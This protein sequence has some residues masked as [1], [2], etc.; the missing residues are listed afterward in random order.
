MFN[1]GNT[2]FK[3]FFLVC[4]VPSQLV[5]KKLGPDVWIPIQVSVITRFFF[6]LRGY[7]YNLQMTGWSLV[8]LSQFWLKDEAGFYITRALLG[9]WEGGF[10][11]DIC[12]YLSYFYTSIELPVRL[13]YFWAA[14]TCSDIIASFLAFGILRMRGVLGR[15]GWRWL[16]LIEGCITICIGIT[17]FFVMPPSPTATASFFRGKNGWFTV[18]EEKIIVNRVLRDDPAKGGMHNR[19]ALDWKML[20]KSMTDLDL[21]PIYIIG[22]VFGMSSASVDTYLTLTLRNVGFTT[23]QT[24]LLVL[25]KQFLSLATLLTITYASQRTD[26]RSYFGALAQTWVLACLIPLRLFTKQSNRWAKYAV[27]TIIIGHPSTHAIQVGWTSRNSNSVR[28]RTVSAAMYNMFCQLSGIVSSYIYRADDAPL[29]N[30]GN[31]SLIGI[32]AMNIV[33]YILVKV[34]YVY[35]N[36]QR[37]RVWNAMTLEERTAYPLTTKDEG[38]RRLDFRFAS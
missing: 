5:S 21:W 38:S 16:F 28:T 3:V 22:L 11:A 29:Y 7:S 37:D 1:N 17:S 14:L 19:Q 27:T 30:R 13:A 23:L 18:R 34:Y 4:E 25:P 10:I 9:A 6:S 20:W 8:A 26:Q 35:R 12:L 32:A 36:K 15:E 24:T 31:S 2:I 33:V